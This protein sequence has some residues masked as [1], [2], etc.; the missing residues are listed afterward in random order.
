MKMLTF[1]TESQIKI[2][3]K[4]CPFQIK[5]KRNKWAFTSFIGRYEAD[6]IERKKDHRDI[7]L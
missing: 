6:I 3:L 2:L 7:S 5:K 4:R 1:V